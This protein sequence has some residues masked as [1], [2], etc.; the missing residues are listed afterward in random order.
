MILVIPDCFTKFGGNQYINST[1]T[2]RYEDYIVNEII[3]FIQNN[4]NI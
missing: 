4:Y 2:G 3:P 1:A